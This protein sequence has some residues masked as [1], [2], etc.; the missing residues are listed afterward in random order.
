MEGLECRAV[1]RRR[2]FCPRL[3]QRERF[4][5][6]QA[7]HA[8]LVI[9]IP[10]F[11]RDAQRRLFMAALDELA[12]I[13]EPVN[14]VLEVD[15]DGRSGTLKTQIA[16]AIAELA[17]DPPRHAEHA[18]GR[19]LRRLAGAV[20]ALETRRHGLDPDRPKRFPQRRRRVPAVAA[21]SYSANTRA[22]RL[23]PFDPSALIRRQR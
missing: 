11:N 3:Q 17:P 4:P 10:A 19:H 20:G 23:S 5:V 18:A 7:L 9:L 14:R 22:D 12:V 6:A 2:R 8:C 21:G 16:A 13:G 1:R 15:L